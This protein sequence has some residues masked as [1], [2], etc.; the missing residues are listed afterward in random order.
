MELG[1]RDYTRKKDRKKRLRSAVEVVILVIIAVM[2]AFFI[3]GFQKYQ[4]DA[5]DRFCR[6]ILSRCRPGRADGRSH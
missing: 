5:D 2:T 1:D 4:P 3:F 6:L